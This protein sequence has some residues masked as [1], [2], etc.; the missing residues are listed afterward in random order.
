MQDNGKNSEKLTETSTSQKKV[1]KPLFSEREIRNIVRDFIDAYIAGQVKVNFPTASTV[2][3]VLKNKGKTINQADAE[4]KALN[5]KVDFMKTV[6]ICTG[7]EKATP[8]E[9]Q[10]A[11]GSVFQDIISFRNSRRLEGVFHDE[12]TETRLSRLEEGMEKANKLI[13]ELVEYL[14]KG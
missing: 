7:T 14:M 9:V 2:I 8:E 13:E 6:A 1:F 4:A 12:G 10:A 3:S 11:I 5:R